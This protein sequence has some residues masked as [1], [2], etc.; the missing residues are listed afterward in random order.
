MKNGSHPGTARGDVTTRGADSD[1]ARA[2]SGAGAVCELEHTRI[3]LQQKGSDHR[4]GSPIRHVTI[5]PLSF[6]SERVERIFPADV[7][8]WRVSS[9]LGLLQFVDER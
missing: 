3:C 1:H 8:Q 5:K 9:A 4:N 2:M 6:S 7:L